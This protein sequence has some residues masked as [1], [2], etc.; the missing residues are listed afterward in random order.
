[1]C[2]RDNL[3]VLLET[4]SFKMLTQGLP[5]RGAWKMNS[6]LQDMANGCS[7]VSQNANIAMWLPCRSSLGLT[8]SVRELY[9][10]RSC[11]FR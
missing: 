3:R 6:G 7:T 1:M 11:R 10:A 9:E 8:V 4:S 2:D 5:P